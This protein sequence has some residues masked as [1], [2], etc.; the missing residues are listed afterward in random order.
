MNEDQ[1]RA[2]KDKAPENLALL[3]RLARNIIK[4]NADKGSNRLEFKR[5]GWEDR[6]L[7]KLISEIAN[8]I[9][10]SRRARGLDSRAGTC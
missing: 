10:L 4:R 7:A 9:A 2:R 5:A 8:A 3:R 1:A 6:F